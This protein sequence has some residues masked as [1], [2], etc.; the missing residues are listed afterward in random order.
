MADYSLPEARKA[1]CEFF[2]VFHLVH[3]DNCASRAFPDG[4]PSIRAQDWFIYL[5]PAALWSE[6]F[7]KTDV[8]FQA[9]VGFPTRKPLFCPW[10]V[11][12]R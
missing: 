3:R 11:A 2:T 6:P 8:D 1:F 9:A 7:Q 5:Y 4:K 12:S 10:R